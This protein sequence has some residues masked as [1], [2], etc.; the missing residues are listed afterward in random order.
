MVF[1]K[2]RDKRYNLFLLAAKRAFRGQ[3]VEVIGDD[4]DKTFEI[5]FN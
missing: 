1:D 4:K 2:A 5:I 3:K